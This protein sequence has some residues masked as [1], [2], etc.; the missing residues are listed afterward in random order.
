MGLA[1]GWVQVSTVTPLEIHMMVNQS[2]KN[3]PQKMITKPTCCKFQ[4]VQVIFQHHIEQL[5]HVGFLFWM[6][7]SHGRAIIGVGHEKMQ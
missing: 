4:V 5:C 3:Q 2:K 6:P 1:V 7:Q